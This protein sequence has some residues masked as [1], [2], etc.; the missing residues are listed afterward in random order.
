MSRDS[1]SKISSLSFGDLIEASGFFLIDALK[2]QNLE[3]DLEKI[4]QRENFSLEDF[5]KL[6]DNLS[7]DRE[8]LKKLLNLILL[9][10]IENNEE[11][12]KEAIAG[13][14]QKQGIT[15]IAVISSLAMMFI[16][17]LYQMRQTKSKK[18]EEEEFNIEETSD[19]YKLSYKKKTMYANTNSGLGKFLEQ[20]LGKSI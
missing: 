3:S 8:E 1:E 16:I 6:A 14:G 17:K 15:E 12:V 2:I 4:A 7:N 20:I 9:T 18:S 11:K 10:S 19:G 13:A 5:S